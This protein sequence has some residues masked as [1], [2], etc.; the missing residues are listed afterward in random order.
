VTA[1][2]GSELGSVVRRHLDE[3]AVREFFGV[4]QS[5]HVEH[6]ASRWAGERE[7]EPGG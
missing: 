2:S 7:S 4:I 5:E 1:E 6:D 3:G